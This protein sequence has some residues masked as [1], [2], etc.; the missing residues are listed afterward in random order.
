MVPRRDDKQ[1]VTIT[2]TINDT[3][4][5]AKGATTTMSS[6]PNPQPPAPPEPAPPAPTPSDPSKPS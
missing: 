1:A 3:T 4:Y 6:T 2:Y 5:Q